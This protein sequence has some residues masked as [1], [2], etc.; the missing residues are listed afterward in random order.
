MENR[1]G[2][3]STFHKI[4]GHSATNM[5]EVDDNSVDLVV[6]SPPYGNVVRDYTRGEW[7]EHDDDITISFENWYWK[8]AIIVKECHRTLKPGGVMA[9]NI[10]NVLQ[11]IEIHEFLMEVDLFHPTLNPSFYDGIISWPRPGFQSMR[12]KALLEKYYDDHPMFQRCCAR[13][14]PGPDVLASSEFHRF[15]FQHITATTTH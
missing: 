7:K 2:I 12:I 4:Y 15:R 9:I 11:L 13:A 1:S 3:Y 6:T 8:L 14:G 5:K 10:S